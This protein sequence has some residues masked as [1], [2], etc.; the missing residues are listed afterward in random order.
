MIG[1]RHLRQRRFCEKNMPRRI[2]TPSATTSLH[3]K[4]GGRNSFGQLLDSEPSLGVFVYKSRQIH[5]RSKKRGCFFA[6][7]KTLSLKEK[8]PQDGIVV[9]PG[10]AG[11]A[12][13]DGATGAK[14][15]PLRK[16]FAAGASRGTNALQSSSRCRRTQ[17]LCDRPAAVILTRLSQKQLGRSF[18]S[19]R[20]TAS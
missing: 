7:E 12:A 17:L 15:L 19:P 9:P 10:G 20:A 18:V 6:R 8:G 1:S 16:L 11:P 4:I 5:T 3:T 2:L 13:S 14:A